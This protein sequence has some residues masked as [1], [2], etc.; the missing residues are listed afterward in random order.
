MPDDGRGPVSKPSAATA[1]AGNWPDPLVLGEIVR[2]IVEVAHPDRI[3]LFGS[4]AHG[5]MGPDSDLDLPVIE[6]GVPPT[7][8]FVAGE[9]GSPLAFVTAE[10]AQA[11]AAREAGLRG[12][13][14]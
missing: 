7:A 12:V 5:T 3:I 2:R 9:L 13:V 8:V 1:T 14:V 4:A 10:G 11:S 6:S